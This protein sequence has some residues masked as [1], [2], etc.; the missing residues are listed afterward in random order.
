MILLFAVS[1]SPS[2]EYQIPF[3]FSYKNVR[4]KCLGEISRTFFCF[5]IMSKYGQILSGGSKM[6]KASLC[7]T[8]YCILN[9]RYYLL[10]FNYM[11]VKK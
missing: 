7:S 6:F 3:K 9:K 11:K 10:K 4:D 8:S 2:H 5:F 1:L